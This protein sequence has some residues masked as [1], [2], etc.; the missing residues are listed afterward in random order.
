MNY[1]MAGCL[2]YN[3]MD[4]LGGSRA[5]RASGRKT[6]WLYQASQVVGFVEYLDQLKLRLRSEPFFNIPFFA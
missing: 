4:G 1:L 5:L 6:G 2:V 3:G